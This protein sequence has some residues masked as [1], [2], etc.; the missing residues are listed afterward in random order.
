MCHC[1][2]PRPPIW[3]EP[4]S[5]AEAAGPDFDSDRCHAHEPTDCDGRLA[6]IAAI[7]SDA[8]PDRP[9]RLRRR[10]HGRSFD[11]VLLAGGE[12][13]DVKPAPVLRCSLAESVRQ[14][15]ARRSERPASA[16]SAQ[17]CMQSRLTMISSA[18]AAI[19]SSAPSSASTARATPSMCA[20]SSLADG[21]A[22]G[23]TDVAVA[24]DVSRRLARERL[25]SVYHRARA[26]LRRLPRGAYSSRSRRAKP[27][28]LSYVPV[29]CARAART[30]VAARFRCPC[31]AAAQAVP[32]RK[33]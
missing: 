6:K 12:R 31:R 5:F 2:S 9:R 33:P 29:G 25:P 15:A 18:A 26:W 10:R 21:R 28:R 20:H 27:P 24:K 32:G 23:L 3:V 19:A 13:V 4:Q 17:L 14:L 30:E 11:A 1:R 7:A 8:A 22:L 16:S